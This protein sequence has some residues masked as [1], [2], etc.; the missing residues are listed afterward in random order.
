MKIKNLVEKRSVIIK[1][2]FKF[3]QV[4][5]FITL[6]SLSLS[7]IFLKLIRTP[8]IP[9]YVLIYMLMIYLSFILNTRYTFKVRGNTV[10]LM[11]YFGSYGIT[12]LFGV[13]LL[14]LFR[15]MLPFENWI[16]AYFVIPFTLTLNFVFS[17]VLFK[18]KNNG[19]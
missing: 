14:T 4:G 11:L 5:V 15:W 9:T 2:F 19:K 17:T 13:C 10:K 18:K 16:L 1:K 7:F 8:L 6:L 3:A 12:M